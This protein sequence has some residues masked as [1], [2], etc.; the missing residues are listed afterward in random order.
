MYIKTLRKLR[1]ESS[2]HT[3]KA[4]KLFEEA[5]KLVGEM[6]NA[7]NDADRLRFREE[8]LKKDAEARLELEKSLEVYSQFIDHLKQIQ[9]RT[10]N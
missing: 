4:L 8:W 3:D 2:V 9:N 10:L 7:E 1:L 5:A 6:K